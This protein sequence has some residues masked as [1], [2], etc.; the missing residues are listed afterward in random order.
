ML[1][2]NR[3]NKENLVRNATRRLQ[4][5]LH[6]HDVAPPSES[7]PGTSCGLIVIPSVALWLDEPPEV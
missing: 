3:Y 5:M 6:T 7:V 4:D 2:G 1:T